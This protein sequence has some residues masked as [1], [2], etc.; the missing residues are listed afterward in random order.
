MAPPL[1]SRGDKI[2]RGQ[3]RHKSR[4]KETRAGMDRD[5]LLKRMP[6]LYDGR[7][8]GCSPSPHFFFSA[9]FSSFFGSGFFSS[10]FDSGFF[11]S[12]FGASVSQTSVTSFTA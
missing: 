2:A 12:F 7:A 9:A 1:K 10:F 4:G 6:V 8:G 11:S 3:V 5:A